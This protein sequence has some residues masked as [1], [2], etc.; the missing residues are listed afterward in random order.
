MKA[1]NFFKMDL[2]CGEGEFNPS[3]KFKN[4]NSLLKLDIMKDWIVML[5]KEYNNTLDE[6][7]DEM[8]EIAKNNK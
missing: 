4:E 5:K 8:K 6:W 2:D 7:Q 3:L 1:T